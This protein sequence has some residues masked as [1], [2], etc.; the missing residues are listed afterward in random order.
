MNS[1]TTPTWLRLCADVLNSVLS[2]DSDPACSLNN[3]S[4]QLL[5]SMCIYN[6]GER[7]NVKAALPSIFNGSAK[8]SR[9]ND[10]GTEAV[11]RG[12]INIGTRQAVSVTH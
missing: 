9:H 8:D 6:A 2:C 10:M 12:A 3:G 5:L 7:A 1:G 11:G 4:R